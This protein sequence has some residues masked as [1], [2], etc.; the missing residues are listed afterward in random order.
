MSIAFENLKESL[1]NVRA[2]KAARSEKEAEKES[3]DE[4]KL[5]KLDEEAR[6]IGEIIELIDEMLDLD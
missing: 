5:T 2:R 3:V 1:E 4:E 6:I